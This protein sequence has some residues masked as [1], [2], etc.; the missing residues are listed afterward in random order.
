MDAHISS[1]PS[2]RRASWIVRFARQVYHVFS[3]INRANK[4]AS[5][6]LLAYGLAESDRAPDTYAEF[7]LRSR[8]TIL[9][10]PTAGR[11]AAGR[12][13]R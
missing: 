3:E 7:L 5:R 11:R 9:H 1:S 10:E 6:L 8:A 13:V 2:T 4:R 12:P